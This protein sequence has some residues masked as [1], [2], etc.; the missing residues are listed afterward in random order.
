[1]ATDTFLPGL[2]AL[3][4]LRA[5]ARSQLQGS[6]PGKAL[7]GLPMGGCEVGLRCPDRGEGYK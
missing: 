7:V 5:S 1:M 2:H 3:L 4:R 6:Q